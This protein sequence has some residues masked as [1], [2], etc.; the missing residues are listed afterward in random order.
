MKKAMLFFVILVFS[1]GI[2]LA[3][4]APQPYCLDYERSN[5]P[6]TIGLA[7]YRNAE[8]GW[9]LGMFSDTCQNP[10]TVVQGVCRGKVFEKSTT[11]CP[12]GAAC[13]KGICVGAAELLP[14]LEAVD[15]DEKIAGFCDE[16]FPA[17]ANEP[18]QP[19]QEQAAACALDTFPTKELAVHLKQRTEAMSA[20]EKQTLSSSLGFEGGACTPQ[21]QPQQLGMAGGQE[22]RGGQ[23]QGGQNG[24]CFIPEQMKAQ[25]TLEQMREFEQRCKQQDAAIP[26]PMM[27]PGGMPGREMVPEMQGLSEEQ[28]KATLFGKEM[29]PSFQQGMNT[30]QMQKTREQ[31]GAPLQ[32]MQRG[33]AGGRER[34]MAGGRE[35]AEG[36]GGMDYC[37]LDERMKQAMSPDQLSQWQARCGQQG[38]RITGFFSWFGNY[39]KR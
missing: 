11:P 38:M 21:P 17:G 10:A 20:D 2:V 16:H 32:G 28:R 25:L 34:G 19:E 3:A 8:S 13:L 23:G 6:A 27:K 36:M 14:I 35:M 24:G 1:A 4:P 30:E 15:A 5:N 26:R 12:T 33:M 39:F 31:M 37:A 29:P 9:K 18:E 7:L 22:G